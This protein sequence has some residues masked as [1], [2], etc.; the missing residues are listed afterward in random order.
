MS[1][2]DK[3]Q[4]VTNEEI[5]QLVVARLRSFPSGKKLSMGSD[6]EFTKDELIRRVNEEDPIGKK[7]IE[8]QL[9]YLRSLK[10]GLVPDQE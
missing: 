2:T 1:K 9:S 5:R 7:V 6:G 8:I 4:S 3:K 10:E